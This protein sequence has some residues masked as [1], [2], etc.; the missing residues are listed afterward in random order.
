MRSLY[1]IVLFLGFFS[2]ACSA[3]E[4]NTDTAAK[5]CLNLVPLSGEVDGEMASLAVQ[6]A[7]QCLSE[8]SYET[9][10]LISSIGGS[11]IAGITAY[12]AF[13]LAPGSKKLKTIAIGPVMSSAVLIFLAGERREMACNSFL[14]IHRIMNN[15]SETAIDI[16]KMEEELASMKALDNIE[17]KLYAQRTGLSFEEVTKLSDAGTVLPPSEAVRLGF[18]HA[19]I[20]ECPK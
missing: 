14:L 12:N 16:R 1:K 4:L 2:I 9:E 17:L 19:I 13:Q 18:A 10:V 11:P 15:K 8:T 3:E 5:D 20:G 7:S 6:M